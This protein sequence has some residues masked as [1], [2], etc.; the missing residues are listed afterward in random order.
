MTLPPLVYKHSLADAV[1][2]EHHLSDLRPS[3]EDCQVQSLG[4]LISL[5]L[6]P[7]YFHQNQ[8]FSLPTNPC[9]IPLQPYFM[10][11]FLINPRRQRQVDPCFVVGLNISNA[12]SSLRVFKATSKDKMI[13]KSPSLRKSTRTDISFNSI[14][15][16]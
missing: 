11:A 1:S 13:D 15:I 10:P 8:Y 6:Q 14:N 9:K 16:F 3:T 2:S 7:R 4:F 12:C 5:C